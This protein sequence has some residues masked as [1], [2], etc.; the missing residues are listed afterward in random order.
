VVTGTGPNTSAVT[1]DPQSDELATAIHQVTLVSTAI[2]LMDFGAP[3]LA[4]VT[5][6]PAVTML[7]TRTFGDSGV[8]VASVG[9]SPGS[10]VTARMV[11]GPMAIGGPPVAPVITGCRA[12]TAEGSTSVVIGH[13]A[14][15]RL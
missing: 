6:G 5:H 14:V 1:G 7:Q 2:G 10:L 13:T 11:S 15:L 4:W 8:R 3:V 9:D 12:T